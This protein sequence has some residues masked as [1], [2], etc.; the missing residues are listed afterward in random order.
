MSVANGPTSRVFAVYDWFWQSGFTMQETNADATL[1][2]RSLAASAG[3]ELGDPSL[4][5]LYSTT[6]YYV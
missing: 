2:W 4:L 1:L 3:G 5:L 6:T